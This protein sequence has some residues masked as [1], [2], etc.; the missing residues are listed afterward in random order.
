MKVG[1]SAKGGVVQAKK[2]EGD[3]VVV[4][5]KGKKKEMV[6]VQ[7]QSGQVA[8]VAAQYPVAYAAA[9]AIMQGV[10]MATPGSGLAV[11]T[12]E[13]LVVYSVASTGVQQS[14]VQQSTGSTTTATS[15]SQPYATIGVPAY[16]DGANMYLQAGQ[17]VQLVQAPSSGQQQQPQVVYWPVQQGQSVGSQLAVVQGSQAILQPVQYAVDAK[18]SGQSSS[19]KSGI[20]TID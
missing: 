14:I 7:D 18:A 17:T 10:Q 9:G 11:Q 13:G 19:G 4:Q 6:V 20:I 16:V 5:E 12:P 3:V 1:P 8:T 2:K 15:S